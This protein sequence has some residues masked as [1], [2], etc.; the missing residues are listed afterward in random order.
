ML[1]CDSAQAE[2]QPAPLNRRCPVKDGP[3]SLA[4]HSQSSWD[5]A[6]SL[7]VGPRGSG[8]I[9]SPVAILPEQFFHSP[10]NQ[11]GETALMCAVL[12][13]AFAYF[14]KQFVTNGSHARHLAKEAEVWFFSND[15]RWP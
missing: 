5:K 14:A 15:E 7:S 2:S 9:L 13:D 3:G 8:L 6:T 4:S 10:R 11:K 1:L 12:E